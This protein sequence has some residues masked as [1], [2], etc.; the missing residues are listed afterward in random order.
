MNGLVSEA[1]KTVLVISGL[2]CLLII[3][4]AFAASVWPKQENTFIELGLLGKDKT[5]DAYLTYLIIEDTNPV[6]LA[7]LPSFL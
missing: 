5:A 4:L 1:H 7:L 6:P 2:L 3:V